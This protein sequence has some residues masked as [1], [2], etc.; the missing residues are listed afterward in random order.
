MTS[1]PKSRKQYAMLARL[2]QQINAEAYFI[3]TAG[4]LQKTAI[5]SC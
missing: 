5:V 1:T 4:F 3:R 2:V